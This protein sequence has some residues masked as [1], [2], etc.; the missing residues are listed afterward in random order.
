[1]S[2][3]EHAGGY[4]SGLHE[5]MRQ[6]EEQMDAE[7]QALAGQA[8]ALVRRLQDAEEKVASLTAAIAEK[9]RIFVLLGALA[10]VVDPNEE[11]ALLIEY[12]GGSLPWGVKAPTAIDMTYARNLREALEDAVRKAGVPCPAT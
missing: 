8:A 3:I 1:V 6:R 5:Q 2:T 10:N 11:D 12:S 9:H 4:R 7:R